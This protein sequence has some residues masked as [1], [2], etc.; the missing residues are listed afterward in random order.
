MAKRL[1]VE[2]AVASSSSLWSHLPYDQW[3]N[4]ASYLPLQFN[5]DDIENEGEV[6]EGIPIFAKFYHEFVKAYN[7]QTNSDH[8]HP[9]IKTQVIFDRICSVDT[10]ACF[11]RW[12]NQ[13]RAWF[14]NVTSIVYT[15]LSESDLKED[16][17]HMAVEHTT[18]SAGVLTVVPEAAWWWDANCLDIIL[19]ALAHNSQFMPQLH[20]I[21]LPGDFTYG[22][23][24]ATEAP[25]LDTLADDRKL[26]IILDGS[27]GE[28]K[29]VPMKCQVPECSGD[30]YQGIDCLEM[31]CCLPHKCTNHRLV[32]RC[33]L[34]TF[35][36][37]QECTTRY[38]NMHCR[39]HQ[40][41]GSGL[42][43]LCNDC[44]RHTK[45]CAVAGCNNTMCNSEVSRC[46]RCEGSYCML[47]SVQIKVQG[48]DNIG[49]GLWC[50]KCAESFVLPKFA[51]VS[52]SDDGNDD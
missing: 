48:P 49:D 30:T 5:Y 17:D 51:T 42:M 41:H 3:R 2:A 43:H 39:G 29:L 40:R 15:P 31:D 18:T 7:V 24:Q 4:I 36:T 35:R 33:G 19:R 14:Y 32:V 46:S 8:Y 38:P 9:G 23:D 16:M 10:F 13:Q 20:T 11:T 52:D 47:H 28:L 44:S 50:C 22:L 26:T 45:G 6:I 25:V 37:H 27:Q 1:A 34:C 21:R 12:L